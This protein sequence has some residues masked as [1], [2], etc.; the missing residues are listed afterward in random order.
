MVAKLELVNKQIQ[1]EM[2]TIA[3]NPGHVTRSDGEKIRYV[4]EKQVDM[5]EVSK[6][7]LS[8]EA[9]N[10]WTNFGPI[11]RRVEH[12][13][14]KVLKLD[15]GLRVVMCSSGTAALHGIVSLHETL[16]GKDLRWVTSSFGYYST[17]Q[18]PL[19]NAE[20]VDCDDRAMLDIDNLDPSSFDG[21]IV[22]NIFGQESNLNRYYR[23]AAA[24]G[25]IVCVDAAIAFGSHK[26][27]ANECISFHHTKPWGFG[28]GGCAIVAA[29]HENLFRSLICFGHEP[30]QPIN[31]RANNGKISDIASAFALT[32][33]VEMG[34]KSQD[35]RRQYRRIAEIGRNVG[36]S[37]LGNVDEHP[38]TPASVP[39]LT[40]VPMANFKHEKLPSGRYYHPLKRTQ[41]AFDIYDRIINIPCHPGMASLS[42][43]D[44]ESAL[45]TFIERC[46][47]A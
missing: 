32:R 15:D 13:I 11:S 22:T 45:K 5:I 3:P 47:E 6:L 17:I 28:E 25:K 21:F 42:D 41:T 36:L 43:S 27:G 46:D 29:E 38:G 30:G 12:E 19:Q 26:H 14:A 18:G 40:P 33:L 34:L 20:I 44:V 10:H 23:Y 31:R 8:C 1:T 9:A 24:H 39:F 4:E 37:I 35:Y 7:L 2:K 16:A